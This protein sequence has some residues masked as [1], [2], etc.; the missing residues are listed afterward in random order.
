MVGGVLARYLAGGVLRSVLALAALLTGLYL[1]ID[2]VR[3]AG[4]MAR[5]Y[6]LFGVLAYLAATA[7]ARLYDLFPFA[8]LIGTMVALARL[9][10]ASELVAMRAGGFDQGRIARTVLVT[11]VVLGLAAMLVGE[12]IAPDLELGARVERERARGGGQLG[13]G[14]GQTLWLRDGPLMVHAG[15]V[16]QGGDQVRFSD[17]R[18]YR[19]EG[20]ERIGEIIRA[21]EARHATGRW[22]LAQATVLDPETGRTAR[23]DDVLEVS[24]RLEP[25]VFRA[26]AT[27]PRLLPLVDIARIRDYLEANGQDA[28]EYRQAFWRRLLYP[29]HV[30]AMLIAGLALLLRL[31]KAVPPGVGAFA[32]VVLGLGY[33]VVQRLALGLA[34]ALAASPGW[35]Q[36]TPVLVFV[37]LAAVL[38]RR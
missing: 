36:L 15:L 38:L 21:P 27:R 37:L 25:E 17:L 35:V 9:S 8:V 30:G 7:P 1:G 26:L 14:A 11:G 34:P 18:I 33:L 32:A 20:A 28:A 13:A 10:S 3:E 5:G 12:T 6:G 16:W 22:R 23:L 29:V 24:S 4:D 31:G 19:L 2:L